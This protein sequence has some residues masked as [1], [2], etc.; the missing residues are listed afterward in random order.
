[1]IQLQ[2][3]TLSVIGAFFDMLLTYC[4]LNEHSLQFMRPKKGLYK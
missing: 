4:L 2:I 3:L 1:M